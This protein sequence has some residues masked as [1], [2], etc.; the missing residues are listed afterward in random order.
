[1]LPANA[2]AAG[3]GQASKDEAALLFGVV[4]VREGKPRRYGTPVRR[5]PDGA[6]ELAPTEDA[7][8]LDERRAAIGLPSVKQFLESLKPPTDGQ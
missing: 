2:G 8:G 6:I 7:D 1:M 5:A 3:A 4:R